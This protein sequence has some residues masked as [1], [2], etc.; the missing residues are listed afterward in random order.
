MN[1][2]CLNARWIKADL[3]HEDAQNFTKDVLN[4]MRDRLSDYQEK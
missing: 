3:T 4:H 2:A 1:V